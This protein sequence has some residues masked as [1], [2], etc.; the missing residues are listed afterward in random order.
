MLLKHVAASFHLP[1]VSA[2]NIRTVQY[3]K[4]YQQYEVPT[5]PAV[6]ISKVPFPQ[7]SVMAGFVHSKSRHF[8]NF[9]SG[10]P[11]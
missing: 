1:S 9:S 7:F 4:P 3:S 8:F 5:I 11:T 10:L 6:V 2:A